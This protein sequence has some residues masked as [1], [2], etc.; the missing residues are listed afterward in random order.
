MYGNLWLKAAGTDRTT[1]ALVE[2]RALVWT[3][4]WQDDRP[5]NDENAKAVLR[6]VPNIDDLYIFSLESNAPVYRYH[7]R[8]DGHAY[9]AMSLTDGDATDRAFYGTIGGSPL[10]LARQMIADAIL[11]A[12]D[13]VL[14]RQT[15]ALTHS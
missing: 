12:K 15:I 5:H 14:S 3:E 6:A 2:A 9:W 4:F 7:A 11:E 10:A 1:E 8:R 13:A